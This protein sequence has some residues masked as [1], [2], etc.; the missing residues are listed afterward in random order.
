MQGCT[1]SQLLIMKERQQ[2]AKLLLLADD[3]IL[4]LKSKRIS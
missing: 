2:K 3:M 4:Y 1:L